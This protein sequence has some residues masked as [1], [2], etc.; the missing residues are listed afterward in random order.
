MIFLPFT[1]KYS[2]HRKSVLR[3]R[4]I[5][6]FRIWIRFY[7]TIRIHAIKNY[8]KIIYYNIFYHKYLHIKKI[9]IW[10]NWAEKLSG[11]REMLIIFKSTAQNF[12]TVTKDLLNYSK[13]GGELCP[14]KQVEVPQ[15]TCG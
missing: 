12:N 14:F 13:G 2:L 5:L 1:H 4:F 15:K 6:D 8:R 11:Y 7:E 10:A 9:W 3:I